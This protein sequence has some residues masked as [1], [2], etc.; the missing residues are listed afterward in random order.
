M[1]QNLLLGANFECQGQIIDKL[2]NNKGQPWS[3]SI[4]FHAVFS[5]PTYSLIFMLWLTPI[6]DAHSNTYINFP[7][8]LEQYLME[9][10]QLPNANFSPSS[11]MLMAY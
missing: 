4:W 5:T 3:E 6:T 1:Q 11:K 2:T 10:T 8:Q 7:M 9:V